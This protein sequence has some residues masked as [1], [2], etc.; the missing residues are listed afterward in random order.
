MIAISAALA[1]TSCAAGK[2]DE[3]SIRVIEGA[4]APADPRLDRA[5]RAFSRLSLVSPERA[6]A[7]LAAEA[8]MRAAP[9]RF[10]ELLS[11]AEA[12]SSAAGGLLALVDKRHD[13]AAGYE[14]ADLVSLNDYPLSTTR[15]DL[16]L[17]AAIMDAVLEMDAAAKADGVALVFAS[18]YR[19]YDYQAGL[20]ARYAKAHGEDEAARFSARPGQSQHQLGTAVD[21]APIDDAFADTAAGRWTAANAGRFGFSLSFPRGLEPVTGYI[22][23][24][25]HYR[26]VTKA[27][28]ALERE[29]FGG[30]QQY[31]LEFLDA[32][33][34]D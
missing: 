25:W 13:L 22:W 33:A 14:P 10:M 27:G 6:E 24:S 2:D 3:A 31:M 17:R 19:S 28:A 4:R 5:S 11:A 15:K 23:E 12:E 18:S 32:Y 20:F 29:F 16:R 9:G 7:A 30:V 21:F 1:S 26:Y 8:A 34:G